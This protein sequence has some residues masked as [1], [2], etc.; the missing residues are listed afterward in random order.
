[1]RQLGGNWRRGEQHSGAATNGYGASSG[2]SAGEH[3]TLSQKM[4]V[5][6][7]EVPLN[8]TCRESLFRASPREYAQ[9][10][11]PRLSGLE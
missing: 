11:L 7:A 5:R 1:M 4:T 8:D 9:P 6:S 2:P 10:G 3:D